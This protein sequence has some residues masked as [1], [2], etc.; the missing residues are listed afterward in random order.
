MTVGLIV[1]KMQGFSVKFVSEGHFVWIKPLILHL[2][3]ELKE[4][5][6][7]DKSKA[8]LISFALF[9]AVSFSL[10]SLAQ[11]SSVEGTQTSGNASSDG[12]APGDAA[13]LAKQLSNPIASLISVPS[14]FNYDSGLGRTDG[15]GLIMKGSEVV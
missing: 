13:E 12:P 11:T 2:R 10:S 4:V 15:L 1:T 5:G 6:V 7:V 3:M 14:Q 9:F 8:V